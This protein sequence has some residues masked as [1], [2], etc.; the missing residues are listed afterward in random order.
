MSYI[1]WWTVHI[2]CVRTFFQLFKDCVEGRRWPLGGGK[3]EGKGGRAFKTVILLWKKVSHLQWA[4]WKAV[5]SSLPE[6]TKRKP[7]KTHGHHFGYKTKEWCFLRVFTYMLQGPSINTRVSD[8]LTFIEITFPIQQTY[9]HFFFFFFQRFCSAITV[10]R[11][12]A[13]MNNV[14]DIIMKSRPSIF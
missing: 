8:Q 6:P 5:P 7:S 9:I 11:V 1:C 14:M 13:S 10:S 3:R 2:T 4:V 12:P